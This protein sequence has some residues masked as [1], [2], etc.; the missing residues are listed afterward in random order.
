MPRIQAETNAA[1]R[2]LT[3]RRI[4][5]AFGQLLFTQGLPGL[6]MTDVA[7][8][9]GV[10]RTAV[11]NYYADMEELLIG[12]ALDETGRFLTELKSRLADLANP[13]DRLAVYIRAQVEDLSRRHLPPGPAMRAVLS[14]QSFAK[15][16]DHVGELNALL[17]AILRDAM[18]QGYLPQ[19]NV[20]E[21][22]G[23]VHGSLTASA[24]R[25]RG[26]DAASAHDADTARRTDATVR[27]IQLGVGA[28]FDDEGRP[29]RR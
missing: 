12:Y 11:Y 26:E 6:T 25:G 27:F 8:Q 13:I 21:L 15:L 28:R 29:V 20:D 9:A 16:G 4:L 14:A 18:D 17:T 10:G 7:R 3:Q 2:A 1:Q 24:D 22:V 19:A 23:L 5:D